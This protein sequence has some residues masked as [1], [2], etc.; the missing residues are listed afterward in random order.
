[1]RLLLATTNPDKVREIRALLD[2]APVV[3]CSL[4]DL[5]PVAE[6]EETGGTF[7]ENARLKADAYD[8]H[9]RAS[10]VIP[11]PFLTVAEDSGL[12]VDAMD[13]EP[14]VYSARFV[15]SDAS[16][17]ERFAE[18]YRRL[19]ERPDAPRTARFVCALAVVDGG[20]SVF[21]TEGVVEGEIAPAPSGAAGFGYDPIFHYPPYGRTLAEVTQAEKLAVAHRGRAFRELRDWIV[22]GGPAQLRA[23]RV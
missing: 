9:A 13:G 10:G 18:I 1:M 17:P 3:L 6:P 12:V 5:P 16:Y 15:R 2:G 23:T 11:E 21:E 20:G 22:R 14:G 8:R 19:G 7:A 4:A